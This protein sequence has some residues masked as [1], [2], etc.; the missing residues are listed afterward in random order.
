M[1][2]EGDRDQDNGNVS[3]IAVPLGLV[4]GVVVGMFVDNLALG[5]AVGLSAGG[6][7]SAL[8]AGRQRR[9]GEGPRD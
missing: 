4:A 9:P 6:A 1:T 8:A 5:L 3:V 7:V 2:N